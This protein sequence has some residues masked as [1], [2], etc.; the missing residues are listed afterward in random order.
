MGNAIKIFDD[1]EYES[2]A[3]L[4]AAIR[5]GDARRAKTIIAETK[6]SCSRPMGTRSNPMD[7][8]TMCATM[9]TYL[10]KKYNATGGLTPLEYA[11]ACGM[12]MN[13]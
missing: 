5:E 2:G 10:T 7:F 4:L 12:C 13:V 11:E 1:E 6:A 9:L 8:D 3:L